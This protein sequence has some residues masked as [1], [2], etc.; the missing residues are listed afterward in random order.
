M[1][2]SP[3]CIGSGAGVPDVGEREQANER[4][5]EGRVRTEL[6]DGGEPTDEEAKGDEQEDV[7]DE[8][9]YRKDGDDDTIVACTP[10]LV[11]L[12]VHHRLLGDC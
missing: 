12:F 9:I 3:T 10:R 2:W 4:G 11:V 5:R 8:R 1:S 6:V 7:R